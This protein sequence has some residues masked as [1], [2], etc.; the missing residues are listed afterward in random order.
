MALLPS[1]R[2]GPYE[3]LSAI[4]A[5]GMGEVYRA[6]DTRLDRIVAI[7]ILPDRLADRAELRERFEREART[8]ASLNHPHI[9]TLYDIGHQDGTDFLVMEYLE[10]ETLAQRLK[11]GPLPLAQVLQYAIEIADALDKAHRKGITHRDLKPGN[12]MLTKSGTK[13][14]DFGLAKLKKDTAP[15]NVTLSKVPTE[16]AVTVQGT[17]LGTLQYMAPEQLE[18][19]AVDARTDIFAFGA[20]VY[21]MTTG[22][23]AFEGKSQASFIAK[24]LEADPPP[25]SSLQPMT[26]PALDRVVK[27]CLAKEPEKRWQAASDVCDELRWI[28]ESGSQA[29]SPPIARQKLRDWLAWSVA[30]IAILVALALAAPYFRSATTDVRSIQFSIS[31]AQGSDLGPQ[32]AAVSPDG[33]HVAFE[34]TDTSGKTLLWVR[35]LDSPNPQPLAGTEGAATPALFWSPDSRFIGFFAEGKLKTISASGGPIQTL[36]NASP[37]GGTWSR[38]GTILF[39]PS[40]GFSGLA[41]VSAIGGVPS[42]AT[43]LDPSR[44]E[45]AHRWPQFLPDGRFLYFSLNRQRENNGI[46][47]GSLD[48]K[49]T[50]RVMS[51]DLMAEYAPPGYLLFMQEHTLIAQPFDVGHMKMTGEPSHLAEGLLTSG[52]GGAAGFSVSERGVLAYTGWGTSRD[53]RLVWFDRAGKQLG[54]VGQPGNYCGPEFSPDE[55]RVAVEIGCN[56]DADIWSLEVARGT[57]TRLT[58]DPA[59]DRYARW[60]PDRNRILF[61]S[62]R[63]G[64]VYNLYQK[65]A[66]G[67]GN[68]ELV[69]QSSESKYPYDWSRDGRFVVYAAFGSGKEATGR[70]WVLPLFG[71]HKP[72]AFLKTDFMETQARFSPDGH[73]MAYVSDESG[74]D[75]VYI[76][77]FPEASGKVLVSTNGGVQPRWRGDGK[78]LFYLELDRKLMAVPVKEGSALEVGSPKSLFDFSFS[79]R[80]GFD[81]NPYAYYQYDVTADGQRFLLTTPPENASLPV[82]VVLNWTAGLKK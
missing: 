80:F 29:A 18:V 39:T 6:R 26:P 25:V 58:F 72:F 38:D 31:P 57:S 30:G 78:E 56:E 60:S 37:W 53:K 14:L 35:P 42:P 66:N 48:S 10:G 13:L 74:K 65:A 45:R 4:G 54:T 62:N 73:W 44:G 1:Q 49:E 68:E 16:D 34:A 82:T 67:A 33:T 43:T 51:T 15:A 52:N 23:K 28:A 21:E 50:T 2:L 77:S 9:C 63:G 5:G 32:V 20:V 81:G 7:K 11:K 8:V 69:M 71:E 75:E 55:K 76:S 79:P 59:N 19:K 24:I 70:L 41:R 47:V 3:I 64:T 17:I 46:F 22:K 12:I 40:G 27:K 36:A 61:Q